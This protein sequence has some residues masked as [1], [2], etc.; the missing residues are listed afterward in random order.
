MP[1]KRVNDPEPYEY[2]FTICSYAVDAIQ[3][4]RSHL[5]YTTTSLSCIFSLSSTHILT[6][7]FP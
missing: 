1:V 6:A 5:Y 7:R 3:L 2:S 4:H